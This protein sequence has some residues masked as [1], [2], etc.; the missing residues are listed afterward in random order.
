MRR[1]HDEA[2]SP[3]L[4][5]F[6]WSLTNY[7]NVATDEEEVL[8]WAGWISKGNVLLC[9]TDFP[10][11]LSWCHI[12]RGPVNK[13][14]ASSSFSRPFLSI[15]H[16]SE[17]EVIASTDCSI[18]VV[19]PLYNMIIIIMIATAPPGVSK[20][21]DAVGR[22]VSDWICCCKLKVHSFLPI[23][24]LII[25]AGLFLLYTASAC[26]CSRLLLK[27]LLN[28]TGSKGADESMFVRMKGST[29]ELAIANYF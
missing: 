4:L 8:W 5:L 28:L 13:S 27:L 25:P 17:V 10:I 6:L 18:V 29:D 24:S 21:T 7:V 3:E 19:V 14:T 22:C 23:I 12:L 11:V 9:D 15:A 2:E 16:W 20:I 26:S 1:W